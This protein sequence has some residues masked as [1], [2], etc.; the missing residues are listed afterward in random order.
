METTKADWGPPPHTH[1]F[2]SFLWC[3]AEQIVIPRCQPVE[4]LP[5]EPPVVELQ[6]QAGRCWPACRA[7]DAGHPCAWPACRAADAGHPS[8]GPAYCTHIVQHTA[9]GGCFE[10]GPDCRAALCPA[11][12]LVESLGLPFEVVGA[13]ASLRLRILPPAWAGSGTTSGGSSSP[14][15]PAAGS[16][17]AAVAAAAAAAAAVKGAKQK[18]YW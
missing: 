13:A 4:L 6:V 5:R 12:Q 16:D 18:Q 10:L 3:A 9:L 11:M 1:T 2:F 14:P 17:A 8:A 7:A 15:P